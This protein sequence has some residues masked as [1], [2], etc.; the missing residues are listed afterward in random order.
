MA[1]SWNELYEK[2]NDNQKDSLPK[3]IASRISKRSN[4]LEKSITA[5][6][7][8]ND[9]FSLYIRYLMFN[10]F[11]E[12]KN[13][14]AFPLPILV[15]GNSRALIAENLSNRKHPVYIGMPLQE[16]RSFRIVIPEA[17]KVVSIPK[18]V[19]IEN[20]IGSFQVI[21]EKNEKSIYYFSKLILKTSIVDIADIKHLSDILSAAEKAKQEQIIFE[22]P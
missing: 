16:D 7:K 1:Y 13:G 17:S 19:H 6:K 5:P 9:A 22:K 10:T 18:N 8:D 20:N 15:G 12:A 21:C 4:V 2:L 14:L 11:E 3:V